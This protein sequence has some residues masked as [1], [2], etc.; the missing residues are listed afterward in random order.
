MLLGQ[1]IENRSSVALGL[2][3]VLSK[4]CKALDGI[5]PALQL[6]RPTGRRTK[7]PMGTMLKRERPC[8]ADGVQPIPKPRHFLF[9]C[10]SAVRPGMAVL[11]D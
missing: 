7:L 6:P 3:A 10:S 9:C 11:R 5:A 2:Y 4:L 1:S 8:P